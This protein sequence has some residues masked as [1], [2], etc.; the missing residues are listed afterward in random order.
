MKVILSGGG[1]GGHIYPAIAIAHA[2]KQYDPATDILF[3]G[4]SGKMEMQK[5]PE[6]G[7][8]I[9]GLGI[10][11]FQRRKVLQNFVLPFRLVASLWKA[12]KVLRDFQPDVV[13]GTGGYASAPILYMAA[14]QKI[15]T[16]IHEQN[17]TIGLTNQILAGSVDTV[18]VAYANMEAFFPDAK[19]VLTGNP[20]REDVIH[21]RGKREAAHAYF[22]LAPEKKCLLV[23]GGSLGAKTINESILQAIDKLREA[24][25]QIIW[26]TGH[27]YF[28]NIKVQLTPQ[29]Q[30]TIKVYPFIKAIDLAYAA[31]DIV[32]SRAGALTVAEL[33]MAQK[34]VVFVPSPNV[35]ADHQTQ[36]VLPLVE[37]NA[38]LMVRDDEAMQTLAKEVL[39]LLRLEGRQ[40]ILAKN[41]KHWAKPQA[42]V[43]IVKEIICL[44]KT[45]KSRR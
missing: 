3:V 30:R 28:E 7:Y 20:V 18:C 24:D 44:A 4:A 39:K 22:G 40:N 21:L 17:A 26:A 27:L 35:T 45:S 29:Q 36:N 42:T 14:K 34:P 32:V 41:M 2:L 16:L 10:R 25:L 15:P 1:T 19:T 9:V 8:P 12:R 13:V 43:A 38:A 33:C 23:L 31:A 37:K 5:V 11:G 6:A